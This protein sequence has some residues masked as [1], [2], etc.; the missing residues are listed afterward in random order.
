MIS[1]DPARPDERPALENDAVWTGPVQRF[2][3]G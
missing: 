1:L 3:A 2:S